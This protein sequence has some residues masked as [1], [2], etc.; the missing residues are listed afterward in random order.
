MQ[1]REQQA[2]NEAE[3]QLKEEKVGHDARGVKN[4]ERAHLPL[5]L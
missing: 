3:N 2:R 4:K 1:Q 5:V